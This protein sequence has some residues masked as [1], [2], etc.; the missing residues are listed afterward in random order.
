MTKEEKNFPKNVLV[1]DSTSFRDIGV[2]FTWT[3][4]VMSRKNLSSQAQLLGTMTLAV[5]VQ[6]S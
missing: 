1:T 5:N 6:S 2:C 3:D 4:I